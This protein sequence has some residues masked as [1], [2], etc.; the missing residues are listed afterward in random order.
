MRRVTRSTVRRNNEPFLQKTL[1]VNALREILQNM[2]LMNRSL[3]GH[4]RSFLVALPA[5]EWDLERRDR[6]TLVFRG[7]D[8]VVS[9]AI[10][11]MRGQSV[12]SCNRFPVKR[13]FMQLLLS[14]VA[15]STL[16]FLK[17]LSVR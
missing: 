6:R 3:S 11:A 13:F 16:H 12:A 17:V 1:A 7:K 4:L 8:I 5:Q 15:G 10:I 9:V 2:V 14:R